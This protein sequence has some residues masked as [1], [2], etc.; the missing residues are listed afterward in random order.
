MKRR[1]ELRLI[2]VFQEEIFNTSAFIR[3]NSRVQVYNEVGEIA[4]RWVDVLDS[5]GMSLTNDDVIHLISEKK[6]MSK[7]VNA[8]F[9]ANPNYKSV[10]ITGAKRLA[11]ILGDQI[12]DDA[13]IGVHFIIANRPVGDPVTT[14]AVPLKI[15]ECE[16]QM[17][18]T[19]LK[20]WLKDKTMTDFDM[21]A[22]IDW[23]YYKERLASSIQKIVTI[24]AIMQKMASPVPRISTPEWLLK[25]EAQWNAQFQ[26][27][28]FNVNFLK[29]DPLLGGLKKG[30]A[31]RKSLLGGP[32]SLGAAG[33]EEVAD[34]EDALLNLKRPP[35]RLKRALEDIP[36]VDEEEEGE[37]V[38]L[39][40]H[41]LTWGP[42]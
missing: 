29:K 24:P 5:K 4:N 7:S 37:D 31:A 33:V 6:S 26:Q 41:I 10:Q 32:G 36:E 17:K 28:A 19:Y 15:F 27:T 14:R 42:S 35:G 21:R 18:E 22:I 34:I 1:G 9:A 25:R 2:Q 40:L 30:A 39:N 13:G 20:E 8:S 16:Q 3:G 11:C 12:L 38:L 23:E